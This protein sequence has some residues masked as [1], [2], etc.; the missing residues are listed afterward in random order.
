M[1]R[2]SL[3]PSPHGSPVWLPVTCLQ[4]A[5]TSADGVAASYNGRLVPPAVAAW[6]D[7]PEANLF[8]S[9]IVYDLNVPQ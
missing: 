2:T 4:E 8:S 1:N 3:P 5:A 7:T 9:S 6:A